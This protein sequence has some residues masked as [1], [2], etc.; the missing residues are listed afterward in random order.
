MH[1]LTDVL[2]KSVE[3]IL[4]YDKEPCVESLIQIVSHSQDGKKV[5]VKPRVYRRK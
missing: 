4:Y 1:T 5:F 2:Q 3:D